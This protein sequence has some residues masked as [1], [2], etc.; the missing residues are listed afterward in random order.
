MGGLVPR[1]E[2]AV[3]GGLPF[4]SADYS[5]FRTH[6]PRMRID[7]PSAPSGRF[8]ARVSAPVAAIDRCPGRERALPAADNAFASVFAVPTGIG[9]GSAESPA[10]A[11]PVA[12]P[13]PSRSPTQGADSV[14]PTGQTASATASPGP[15]A[16]PTVKPSSDRI[17][18]RTRRRTATAAGT[19]P[20]A[21]DYG[22]GPGAAPRPSAR[23]ANTPPRVARPRPGP[24]TAATPAPAASSVPTVPIPSDRDRADPVGTPLLR[25]PPPLGDTPPAPGC[26]WRSC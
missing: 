11:T 7:D 21:V 4:T 14:E 22:F 17:S 12:Q 10:A 26:P 24:P 5:D 3:L 18:P 23:R 16:P 2:S 9:E 13:T 8:V 15:P 1:T 19:A 25:L 6:G 20:P